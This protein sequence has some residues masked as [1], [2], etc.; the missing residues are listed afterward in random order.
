[1]DEQEKEKQKK[2][3]EELRQTAEDVYKEGLNAKHDEAKT[4]EQV[5]LEIQRIELELQNQELRITQENLE[6]I[7]DKYFSFYNLSPVGYVTLDEKAVIKECNLSAAEMLNQT[8]SYLINRPLI[9][10]IDSEYHSEVFRH[11]KNIFAESEKTE[12]MIKLRSDNDDIVMCKMI[13][14]I[15]EDE[16]AEEPRCLSAII[17]ITDVLS[18]NKNDGYI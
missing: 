13:S 4:I 16:N 5:N 9:A 1:M 7:R 2:K 8:K 18:V 15:T 14:V 6:R 17:G 10:F 3:L 12:S 11:V